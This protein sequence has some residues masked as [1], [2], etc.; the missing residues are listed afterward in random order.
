MLY[1]VWPLKNLH[2]KTLGTFIRGDHSLFLTSTYMLK[3]SKTK[4]F[5]KHNTV[6]YRNHTGRCMHRKVWLF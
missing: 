6:N 2:H 4:L 5:S 1:F 3:V